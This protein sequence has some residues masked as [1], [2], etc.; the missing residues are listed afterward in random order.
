MKTRKPHRTILV[1][2]IAALSS[3]ALTSVSS[4]ASLYWD[5]GS[6]DILV[7]GNG[8]S[9]GG[10]GVWDTTI[11][12]WDEGVAPYVAWDNANDDT[13]VFGGIAGA[14]NLGANI[15]LGDLSFGSTGYT[16]SSGANTFT[17]GAVSGSVT[18]NHAASATITGGVIA[19]GDV[20]FLNTS[21]N[22]GVITLNGT[23]AGGISGNVTIGRFT[24]LSLAQ[25]NAALQDVTAISL[26]GGG[27]TLTNADD[28]EAVIDRVNDAADV[29]AN[30]GTV[31]LV[32]TPGA[33]LHGEIFGSV[34]LTGG[35][36][37]FVLATNQ[38]SS[39]NQT[40]TLS[41]LAR[42]GSTAAVTYS[43]TGGLNTAKNRI[44][45]T[46]A[47]A[48]PNGEIIAP[49]ATVGTAVNSQTDYAVYNNASQV[50]GSG[51]AA[52]VETTWTNANHLYTVNVAQTLTA[53][54][55]TAALRNTG[56]GLSITLNASNL[57]TYGIL[58]GGNGQLTIAPGTGGGTM[59][60]P[61]G[62]D[63]T[64]YL[65]AGSHDIGAQATITDNG[66]PVNI[67]KNGAG[68][69][70][71]NPTSGTNT[72]T[73]NTTVNAGILQISV[74]GGLGG[75]GRTLSA[76]NRTVVQTLFSIDNT[77][78]NRFVE[79][80][81]AFYV[82]VGGAADLANANNLDFSSSTGANL[83]NAVLLGF[84]AIG[85]GTAQV[86]SGTLTPGGSTYRIAASHK[87][88]I[89]PAL[90]GAG[91]SLVVS[92]G[93]SQVNGGN[94]VILNAAPTYGGSTTVESG[95]VLQLGTVSIAG[96]APGRTILVETGGT[97]IR[98]TLDNAFLSRMV[99]TSNFISLNI[100]GASANSV[101]FSKG[102][103]GAYL[104]NASLGG[105]TQ[106][107]GNSTFTG[108]FTPADDVY[109]L[110]DQRLT[111]GNSSTLH[112]SNNNALTGNRSLVVHGRT[113][114]NGTND[115]TGDTTILPPAAGAIVSL[116]LGN[117]L[118]MQNS[119]L[120]T[121]T[122]GGLVGL[123]AGITLPTLGG[124]KGSR[125][126]A[127]VI[128]GNYTAMTGI[129]LNPAQ[130]KNHVYSG[131]IANGALGTTLTKNGLGSQTLAGA[132][133][134]TG[135]TSINAGTL[136]I[137]GSISG[138][139][140]VNPTGTLGGNGSIS[141]AVTVANGGI[142]SPGAPLGTLTMNSD[143]NLSAVDSP[144][145][146][147]FQIGNLS[148]DRANLTS[149]TLDIGSDTLGFSDF[150]FSDAGDLVA[151]TYILFSSNQTIVGSL[152]QN[153]LG[154][155]FGVFTGTLSLDD[156]N[157]DILLTVVPEPSSLALLGLGAFG[158]LRPRRQ[159]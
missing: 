8:I 40:L 109:R 79:N 18:L 104:P 56:G 35:Q 106:N 72:Y 148:S 68:F 154:G 81:N 113:S 116:F 14:V 60:T 139:A 29:T 65:T 101:D 85:T 57:A 155:S 59:T 45:V 36:S 141:G 92:T 30:G 149:G 120:D 3:L 19:S 52:S 32:N 112:L 73:G 47:L 1:T 103:L 23:A 54:R 137:T 127:A 131:A 21:F 66:N 107:N 27:L 143:L 124:L 111:F 156:G 83:P 152:D 2:T 78:L 105:Y 94:R 67:V 110:G 69:L 153:D 51:V 150:A 115:F 119:A 134:Y 22:A 123:N 132:N 96:L 62:G 53:N 89:N 151:G 86:Y 90:S 4:A 43:A 44:V 158:L 64:L 128:T 147:V 74:L 9:A 133:T 135:L 10:A 144:A 5:G 61:T 91:N 102:G 63:N 98:T 58:N 46:G 26:N 6:V 77:F 49:W 145:S 24:T 7:D 82:R 100:S 118:A 159:S 75:T 71:L 88:Q 42:T 48:T 13:A 28:A 76:G 20:S 15:T 70:F 33:A 87:F 117:N 130:D 146:L 93:P 97:I 138:S 126:L 129:I 125:N 39:G 140:S 95:A 99:E 50:V 25:S 80:D 38:T 136:V 122:S 41:G 157:T 16:I 11:L 114:L 17:F 12:N 34:E 108:T 121:G 142:L 37:N 84:G 31:T 55:M